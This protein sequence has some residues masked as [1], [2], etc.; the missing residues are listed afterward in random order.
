M[1]DILQNGIVIEFIADEEAEVY[2]VLITSDG[3][4]LEIEDFEQPND[5]VDYY[6]IMKE[7]L[8][9]CTEDDIKNIVEQGIF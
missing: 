8:K 2:S 1:K 9:Y 3:E 5:A 4:Y 7:Q 6:K